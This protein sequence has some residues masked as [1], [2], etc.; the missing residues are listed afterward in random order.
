MNQ[1]LIEKLDL[2][3]AMLIRKASSM[4]VEKRLGNLDRSGYLILH[5]LSRRSS[6]G[7]KALAEEFRLDAS[8]MSR[9]IAALEGKGYV[10][11][12]PDPN[13]GRASLFQITDLGSL[14]FSKAK[15]AR[16][17]RFHELFESWTEEEG[18]QF[19]ELIGRLN[20]AD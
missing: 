8:T 9:Q 17:H 10:E 3:M 14:E 19:M 20:R 5:Y 15:E 18:L 16:I 2:E 11:R 1:E 4:A 6:Q 12:L 13:D 7:I